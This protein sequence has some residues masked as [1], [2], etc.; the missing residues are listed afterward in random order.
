MHFLEPIQFLSVNV[1]LQARKE[2]HTHALSQG[3]C[4]LSSWREDSRSSQLV[5]LLRGAQDF[6]VTVLL[7]VQRLSAWHLLTTEK[8]SVP[9]Q[10]MYKWSFA[11]VPIA[12]SECALHIYAVPG[13][14]SHD[15]PAPSAPLLPHDMN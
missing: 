13:I 1:Y 2:K 5:A 11:R 3:C 4:L 7:T 9:L 12:E 10:A 8:F 15:L 6:I 14:I